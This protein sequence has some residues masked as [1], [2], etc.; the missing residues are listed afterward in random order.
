MIRDC[1]DPPMKPGRS[2]ARTDTTAAAAATCQ[3]EAY[4]GDMKDDTRPAAH[5]RPRPGAPPTIAAWVPS[6]A[7]STSWISA[8]CRRV[9][10]SVR[11][12]TV[13]LIR[14]W[15]PVRTV[16]GQHDEPR[17]HCE[18]R[19]ELDREGDLG[20]NPV[21]RLDHKGKVDRGHIGKGVDDGPLDPRGVLPA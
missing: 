4:D 8:S 10:P 21:E 20:K 19:H 17:R 12:S 15:R 7:Y 9:A 1:R 5:S 14:W 11:R 2:T 6:A 3:A 13:S 18:Q 16:P